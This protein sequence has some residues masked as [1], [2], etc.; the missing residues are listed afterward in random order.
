MIISE[1]KIEVNNMLHEMARYITQWSISVCGQK[2]KAV[3]IQYGVELFFD[4]TIKYL[5]FLCWGGIS[6]KMTETILTLTIFSGI[7]I[8]A[9]GVHAKTSI[10]CALAMGTVLFFSI[11]AAGFIPILDIWVLIVFLLG[12]LIIYQYAPN[13]NTADIFL[14]EK[15]RKYKRNCSLVTLLFFS[16]LAFIWVKMRNLILISI[17]SEITTILIA[18]VRG[19]EKN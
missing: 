3:I 5:L 9:G 15:D 11:T 19:N 13:G 7:R 12:T 6:G 10:G 17:L 16:I 2:E 14:D 18:E 1:R 8:S 4:T